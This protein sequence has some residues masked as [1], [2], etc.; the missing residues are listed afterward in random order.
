MDAASSR[1]EFAT[2]TSTAETERTNKTVRMSKNVP[3]T[4]ALTAA[5]FM[6]IKGAMATST[7]RKEKTNLDVHA[8][9]MNSAATTEPACQPTQGAIAVSS[10]PT[11]LTKPV[12][13]LAAAPA[14]S[15]A[16]LAS[17]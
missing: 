6:L 4:N 17:V 13:Q 1:K 2:T 7:A 9:T 14:S 11:D 10:A 16:R 12:A 5:A 8:V 3:K 15:S